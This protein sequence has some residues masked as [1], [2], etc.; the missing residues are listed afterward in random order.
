MKAYVGHP[1]GGKKALEMRHL[2]KLR[3]PC[4]TTVMGAV[5]ENGSEPA[6]VVE[7]MDRGSLYVLLHNTTVA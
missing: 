5:L 1:N 7:Y 2:S 6:L 4:I 3:H